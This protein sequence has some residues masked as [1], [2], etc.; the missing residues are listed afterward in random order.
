MRT[1]VAENRRVKVAEYLQ[2]GVRNQREISRRL[3]EDHDISASPPTISRDMKAMHEVYEKVAAGAIDRERG[4]ALMRCE[5]NIERLYQRLD[6]LD[7]SRKRA[8]ESDENF[9]E[10]SELP[11]LRL[12]KEWEERKSKL[13]GL[14]RPSKIAHTDPTGENEYTGIPESFRK[15][16]LSSLGSRHQQEEEEGEIVE[17]EV[18]QEIEGDA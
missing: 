2:A 12:I 10:E 13:L 18:V 16:F 6:R 11:T 4:I 7:D 1:T 15:K 14:D 3:K 8:E 17:A 5:E 9:Y